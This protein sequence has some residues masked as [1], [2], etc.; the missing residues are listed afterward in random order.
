MVRTG[1]EYVPEPERPRFLAHLFE[2]VV[3]PSGRLVVG[4]FNEEADQDLRQRQVAELGYAVSGS[5]A[6][7]H[8]HPA[9]RRKAFWINAR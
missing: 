7:P 1:L 3:A 8:R 4:I 5:L 6:E 2:Y 9:V